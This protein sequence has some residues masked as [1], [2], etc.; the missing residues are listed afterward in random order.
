MG[1]G[2]LSLTNAGTINATG[3][4]AL[5]IDTGS[6]IV[7]NSGVL[8]ASGSGGLMVVSAIENSGSLWANGADLT[9]QG[10]V[11]GRHRLHRRYRHS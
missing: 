8:E 2:E 10:A 6:N 9:I 5:V 11:S 3:T 7:V 4:H 1:N